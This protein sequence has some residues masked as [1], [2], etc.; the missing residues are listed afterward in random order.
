[1]KTS[2]KI[3]SENDF[4]DYFEG[5]TLAFSHFNEGIVYYNNLIPYH[6][7]NKLR[8]FTIGFVHE[9][10]SFTNFDTAEELVERLNLYD[11]CDLVN[12]DFLI[13][14]QSEIKD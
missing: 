2:I 1:M 10:A 13:E 12:G 7:M 9:G 11:I 5:T 4:L 8:T 3:E 14:F 6:D